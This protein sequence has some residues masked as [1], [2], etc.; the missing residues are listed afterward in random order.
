MGST[1]TILVL[2]YL[3]DFR[4]QTITLLLRNFW[5]WKIKHSKTRNFK[6]TDA[7]DTEVIVIYPEKEYEYL[8]A[9]EGFLIYL[10]LQITT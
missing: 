6:N 10:F 3:I 7:S 4:F 5:C 9:M 2:F 1:D 8:V